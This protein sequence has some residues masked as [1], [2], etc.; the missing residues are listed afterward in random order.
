MGF[1][2]VDSGRRTPETEVFNLE[3]VHLE[4]ERLM[5]GVC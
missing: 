4:D 3:Q 1:P 5:F 2:G